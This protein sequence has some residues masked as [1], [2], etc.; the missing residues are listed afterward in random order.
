M[1][2]I[3]TANTQFYLSTKQW[4]LRYAK[5]VDL[6]HELVDKAKGPCTRIKRESRRVGLREHKMQ[7]VV[8]RCLRR[9]IYRV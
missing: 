5:S 9:V 7:K 1:I 2:E 8:S 3:D 4:G 6:V